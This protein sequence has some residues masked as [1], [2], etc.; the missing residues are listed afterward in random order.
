MKNSLLT[1]DFVE[2]EPRYKAQQYIDADDAK[3]NL[4][5]LNLGNSGAILRVKSSEINNIED[6]EQVSSSF[7]EILNISNQM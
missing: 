1:F 7:I 4:E 6:F 5:L 2:K 3:E